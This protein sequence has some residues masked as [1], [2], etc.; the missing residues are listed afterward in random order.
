M[1]AADN[2]QV[3]RDLYEAFNTH[4]FGRATARVAPDPPVHS[5]LG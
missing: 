4:D 2:V 5:R 3:V 1:S